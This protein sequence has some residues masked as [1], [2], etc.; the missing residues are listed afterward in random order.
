MG[1]P[2]GC[3]VMPDPSPPAEAPAASTPPR[4][5]LGWSLFATVAC[6]L[7]L[8]LVALFFGFRTNRA[9]LDGRPA[10]AARN[11]RRA[12]RWIVATVVIGVVIY[13]LLGAAL[14]LLGAFSS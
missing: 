12:R 2:L 11:S 4:A 5:Y 14:V 3:E 1:R 9:V 7:P 13:L 6:F 10:D 8:G